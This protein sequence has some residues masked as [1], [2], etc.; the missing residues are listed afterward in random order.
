VSRVV[1]VVASADTAAR[2][3]EIAHRAG[4]DARPLAASVVG[5]VG[6]LGRIAS[7]LDEVGPDLVLLTSPHAAALLPP[8]TGDGW[9]AACV[10]P[11]TAEAAR[12]AGFTVV[13]VGSGTGAHLA[14]DLIADGE[15]GLALFLCGEVVRPDALDLL[16]A[17][18]WRVEQEV[19]YAARPRPE[20]AAE[21]AAVPAPDAIAVGS[22]EAAAALARALPSPG[23][24]DRPAVAVGE[25]T[26]A[27]LRAL[28]FS[29]VTRPEVPR[30]GAVVGALLELLPTDASP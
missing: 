12:A 10:G 4:L 19:V 1:W 6:D 20:F 13:H 8:G 27:R 22:P 25:T 28:G 23:L 17:A 5:P 18:G 3:A 30:A 16:E 11:T 7:R 29:R 21:V 2:W 9:Q 26:A 24:R 14:R 15:P